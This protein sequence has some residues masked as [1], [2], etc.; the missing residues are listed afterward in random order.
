MQLRLPICALDAESK[1]FLFSGG[2]AGLQ[3]IEGGWANLCVALRKPSEAIDLTKGWTGF[4]DGLIARAPGLAFFIANAEPR[5]DRPLAIAGV[6]YGF[7]DCAASDGLFRLGDQAAVI[8]SFCGDG[9]SIALASAAMATE[10]ILRGETAEFFQRRFART[11]RSPFR[12]AASL[13]VLGHTS[14]GRRI[15]VQIGR[16]APFLI[17]SIARKTRVYSH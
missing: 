12:W 16:H 14:W 17:G 8:P 10:A 13:G 5:W 4:R 6:P 9:I 1:M 15:P 3:P 11:V 7:V 2:Y